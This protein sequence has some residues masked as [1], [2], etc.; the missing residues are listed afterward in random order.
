MEMDREPLTSWGRDMSLNQVPTCKYIHFKTNK[1]TNNIHVSKVHCG[2]AFDTN[3]NP[4]WWGDFGQ[5]VKIEQLKF[6]GIL[7]Y[8]VDLR[9]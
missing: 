4:E 1:Q 3:R 2:S 6:L 5:L 7:W 9:F 8:K